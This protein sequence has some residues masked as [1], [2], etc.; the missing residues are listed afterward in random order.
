VQRARGLTSVTSSARSGAKALNNRLAEL[1]PER[2]ALFDLLLAEEAA[3]QSASDS[4]KRRGY[5]EIAPLSYGQERLWFLQQL[6]PEAALFSLTS[7]W[8]LREEVDPATFETSLNEVVRRH[9]TLRTTFSVRQGEPVQVIAP[10]RA[11]AM[12][13]RDLRPLEAM[14][15]DAATAEIA[16]EESQYCFDLEHGPLLRA[17]LVR[18]ADDDHLVIVTMHHIITDGWSMSVFWN[19]LSTIWRAQSSGRTSALPPPELQFGDVAAW[20]RE[21]LQGS[22]LTRLLAYWREQLRDLSPLEFPLDFPRPPVPSGRGAATY[23]AIPRSLTEQVRHLS[24]EAGTTL[25]MTLLA[26]FQA[27]LHRYTG[28]DDIVVGTYTANRTRA[29]FEDVI[30]FFVNPLV[31]RA[32]F[33]ETSTF[34]SL[35]EQV[36]QTALD[37]YAHQEL[38]FARLVQELS[39]ER[40]LSRNPLFQFAFQML[41]APDMG[42]TETPTESDEPDVPREAAVLDLTC[43]VW[44][45]TSGIGLEFEYNTDVFTQHTIEDFSQHYVTLLDQLVSAPD[46]PLGTVSLITDEVRQRLLEEWNETTS[47]LPDR[48]S[49]I[50]MFDEQ[51][52][53]NPERTAVIGTDGAI[54][55]RDLG[56]S[57]ARL[58]SQLQRL[59]VGPETRV[60]V[61]LH[62]SP[63]LVVA[64]L[65]ILRLG[66]VYVPLDPAHPRDRLDYMMSDAELEVLVTS[67]RARRALPRVLDRTVAIDSDEASEAEDIRPPAPAGYAPGSTAYVIYTSGS[68]GLPKGVAVPCVQLV[69]RMRW[70]WQEYPFGPTEVAC[71]KTSVGFVDSMWELLGALLTGSP[72]VIVPD[73]DVRDLEALVEALNRHGVTRIWVV[74]SL[75]REMLLSVPDLRLRLPALRFWVSSGEQLPRDLV[76][77][78]EERLPGADLYNLYGTSE[79]WDATWCKVSG[80]DPDAPVSIGLPIANTQAYVLD[81]LMEPVP[82]GAVGELY[83]G[84]LGL[85]RGYIGQPSLTAAAFLPNP[86]SHEP[87]QR[88]YRTGD[89]ARHQHDGS[90]ILLGRRDTMVKLRG[91]RIETSEIEVC[92]AQ[93]D[94]MRRA[95]VVLREDAVLGSVQEPRLVAYVQLERPES[96]VDQNVAARMRTDLRRMLPEYMIPAVFMVVTE[97]PT[98]ASGKVDRRALPAPPSTRAQVRTPFVAP[99][100]AVETQ[101][102]ELWAELLGIDHVGIRDN[103]FELR[104]HS[105]LGIRMIAR[106][107]DAFNAEVP[108]RAVFES[109]TVAELAL[110]I[111]MNQSSGATHNVPAIT[112]RPREEHAMRLLPNGDLAKD[113]EPLSIE[114]ATGDIRSQR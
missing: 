74:P 30:G 64:L 81:D 80:A 98:T 75:L 43:T 108:L 45:N 105:L 113:G 57:I 114:I 67:S 107:R 27:L 20:E 29:E 54:S 82:V 101:L 104:G 50:E 106:V 109:P 17:T 13:F 49:L 24:Y 79:V 32:S 83:I 25:F 11:V 58:A 71:Q 28:Q 87:G 84:G 34:R 37:A 3:A 44:E 96:I 40:D 78:F 47:D 23:L 9:E 86:F 26:A 55:Y 94:L 59:G 61:C 48:P 77:M 95:V 72:T 41:N 51:V 42:S 53:V 10:H 19:E 12:S 5:Q 62:R 93:S 39:P 46:R 88:L 2:R 85:A 56:G 66:G 76:D 70:M 14:T 1:S 111:E 99:R 21:S 97:F 102:A 69:N 6:M 38:P 33:E 52:A 91:H 92:L 73:E 36:R 110:R 15:R 112:R 7:A 35:L 60:G 89:L 63:D 90:I 100:T 31:L 68:T 18:L 103:F 8:R 4:V 65:A 22:R 16:T